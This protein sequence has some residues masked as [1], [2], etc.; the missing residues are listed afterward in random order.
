MASLNRAVDEVRRQEA[1]EVAGLKATRYLWL[2]NPEALMAGQRTALRSLK[3]LDLK[4]ARA[5]LV[6]LALRRFWTFR[7]PRVA[8]RS[9][10]RWYS[11]ATHT[12]WPR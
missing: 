12:G 6:K 11:W 9:L 2:K 1:R 3:G 10:R 5:Y 7:Y 4:T 8:A